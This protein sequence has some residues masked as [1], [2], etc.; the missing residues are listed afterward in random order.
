MRLSHDFRS[1]P[2]LSRSGGGTHMQCE[3]TD[4]HDDWNRLRRWV[5][6]VLAPSTSS[7]GTPQVVTGAKTQRSTDRGF[8][9]VRL[10]TSGPA[11]WFKAV[12]SPNEAEYCITRRIAERHPRHSPRLLACHD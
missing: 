4:P 10:E 12:G 8:A 2:A 1:R 5:D 9:L 11:V 7:E 3:R 6:S